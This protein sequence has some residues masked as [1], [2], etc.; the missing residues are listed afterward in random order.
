V[1]AAAVLL[2]VVVIGTG[3]VELLSQIVSGTI[4]SNSVLTPLAD[5]F[6]V[7]TDADL[8]VVPSTDG[9]V[10]VHTLV[11][12]GLAQP[13][14]VQES[15]PAGVRLDVDCNEML[16]SSCEVEYTVE[17]PPSFELVV[18]GMAGDV[19]ARGLTG[20]V[21]VDRETGDIALFDVTGPV[22][23]TSIWGEI[24]AMGLGS[25]TVRAE[26]RTG[27]VRLEL[28]EPPQSVQVDANSG[29]VDVAVPAG[30]SYRVSAWTRSGERAVTVPVDPSSPRMITVDGGSGDVRLRTG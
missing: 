18:T 19:T 16:V 3:A 28:L 17:L 5:R 30:A 26:S 23:V 27:D 10:R 1:L 8:T 14:L 9:Q 13:D 15:T 29:E 7:D 25:D 21:R 12:H 24:T 2:V 22:D 11:R 4:E 20:P 6:T